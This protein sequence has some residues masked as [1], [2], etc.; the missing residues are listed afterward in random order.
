MFILNCQQGNGKIHVV[1][2]YDR[3]GGKKN[4]RMHVQ[5]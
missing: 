2:I 5:K 4:K 1:K 3:E